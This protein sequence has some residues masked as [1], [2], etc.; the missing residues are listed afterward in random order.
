[1]SGLFDNFDDDDYEENNGSKTK[2]NNS[3]KTKKRNRD[4]N[5]TP[6]EYKELEEN[7]KK[8]KFETSIK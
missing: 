5:A 2:V 3:E 6:V 4:K 8:K 1:M 7:S